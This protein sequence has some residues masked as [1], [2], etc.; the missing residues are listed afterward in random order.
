MDRK[1]IEQLKSRFDSIMHEDGGVQFWLAREL[2][3]PLGYERWE[4][5]NNA[6]NRAIISCNE[7][8]IDSGD[9]FCETTTMK[10][11]R[12]GAQRDLVDFMLTRYACY[13][14]AENG[15]PRKESLIMSG[16]LQGANYE[17]LKRDYLR[18]YM[19]VA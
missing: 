1:I 10:L 3:E 19:S 16:R 17:N 18:I 2:M 11:I 8:G 9:H 15:D 4:N 5:F 13:L 14:I 6:I 12:K 7:S